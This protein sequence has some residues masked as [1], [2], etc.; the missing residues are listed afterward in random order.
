MYKKP[1]NE[2]SISI[3]I[4]DTYKRVRQIRL[5]EQNTFPTNRS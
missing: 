1:Q 2:I 3:R 5:Q 4:T